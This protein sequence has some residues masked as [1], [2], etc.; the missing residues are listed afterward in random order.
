MAGGNGAANP[1]AGDR[2]VVIISLV[3]DRVLVERGYEEGRR[4]L[5]EGALR[6]TENV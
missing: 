2:L 3:L 4:R 1:A 5:V 6:L